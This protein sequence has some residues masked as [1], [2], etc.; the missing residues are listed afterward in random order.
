MFNAAMRGNSDLHPYGSRLCLLWKEFLSWIRISAAEITRSI[1][2]TYHMPAFWYFCLLASF[3][4]IEV[5]VWTF[6]CQPAILLCV[7]PACHRFV[8]YYSFAFSSSSAV[9]FL[10][11]EEQRNCCLFSSPSSVKYLGFGLLLLF[12]WEMAEADFGEGLE[13]LTEEEN[14][15]GSFFKNW[16]FFFFF[17]YLC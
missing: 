13:D 17:S 9:C 8:F 7:L 1:P 2:Q 15:Y 11:S 12:S 14:I 3:F 10:A 6:A 5:H 16:D 4:L